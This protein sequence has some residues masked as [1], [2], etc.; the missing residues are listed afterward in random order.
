MLTA[1]WYPAKLSLTNAGN[2]GTER[3]VLLDEEGISIRLA[4]FPFGAILETSRALPAVIAAL[5]AFC[6]LV[7][8]VVI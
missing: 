8:G 1:V 3:L 2:S 4:P 7:C 5:I 6:N